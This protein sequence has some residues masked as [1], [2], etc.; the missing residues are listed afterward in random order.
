MKIGDQ[1]K[2]LREERMWTQE[3]LARKLGIHTPRI[4]QYET[5]G[6]TPSLARIYQFASVFK[7][8]VQEFEPLSRFREFH[9]WDG[10]SKTEF[11]NIIYQKRLQLHL[12]RIELAEAVGVTSSAIAGYERGENYPMN[13]RTVQALARSLHIENLIEYWKNPHIGPQTVEVIDGKKRCAICGRLKSIKLFHKNRNTA[14]GLHSYC[15]QCREE[16][17]KGLI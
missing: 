1:L 11:G 4:A 14:T 13:E 5:G 8:S 17:R 6:V 16:K 9:R 12:T 2:Q 15:K 10:V 3:F 7:I